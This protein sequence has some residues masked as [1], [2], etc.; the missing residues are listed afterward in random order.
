MIQLQPISTRTDPLCPYTTLFRSSEHALAA[1]FGAGLDQRRQQLLHLHRL[2]ERLAHAVKQIA[3]RRLAVGIAHRTIEACARLEIGE[4]PI[5]RETP[6]AA[7]Q[8]THE[9]VGVGQAD[10]SEESRV[11]KEGVREC[12]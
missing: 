9:R 2:W 1:V 3:E 4:L 11:G 5:V 8:L 10:R 7:P 6:V 12:R